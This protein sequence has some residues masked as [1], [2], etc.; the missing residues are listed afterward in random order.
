MTLTLPDSGVV[1]SVGYVDEARVEG[2]TIELLGWVASSGTAP[3]DRLTVELDGELQPAAEVEFGIVS[4]DVAEVHPKLL[5]AEK[6]RYRI[7][8][9]NAV[10]EAKPPDDR[11]LV[12]HPWAGDAPARPLLHVV[13][14]SIPVP[15]GENLDLV[16]GGINVGYEFLAHLTGLADL[17][18][19]EAVLDI[20]C[21][22]GRIA[23]A[24][25]SYLDGR[26]RYEGFDIVRSLVDW[27]SEQITSRAPGFRFTHADIANDFYN[28]DG[29]ISPAEYRFP[30]DDGSF[31]LAFLTSVFT[32][33]QQP[34]IEHYLDEI[35]RV[36]RPGGRCFVTCFLLD[37]ESR[38]SQAA[39]KGAFELRY[40]VGGGW[41]TDP[42][43]PE[44]AIGFE[45]DDLLGWVSQRGFKLRAAYPGWW[46]GRFPYLTYQDVLVLDRP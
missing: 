40:P 34:A 21:G 46:S 3:I 4:A 23:Y 38:P 8:I 27:A 19:D 6:S 12:V 31:D 36:L 11:L 13:A 39:G 24:L 29:R 7:L 2:T 5:Q 35:W 33:M 22:T 20:G 15:P 44:A 43:N 26:A 18:P 10:S 45:A 16:G 37:D 1:N 42:S 25:R 9:P 14:P 17:R 41:C 32:H 28:R 30:Y